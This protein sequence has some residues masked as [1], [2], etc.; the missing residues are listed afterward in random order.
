MTKRGQECRAD[1][2]KRIEHPI[3][4][5]SQRENATLDEF[6]GE[7]TRMKRFLRVVRFNVGDVPQAGFP[8]VNHQLPYVSRIF[9]ERVAA[10]LSL[11]RSSEVCLAGI[12]RVHADSV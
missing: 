6:D 3:V 5:V 11:L 1:S 2:R 9:P 4:F 10:G 7:L 12:F 8:F